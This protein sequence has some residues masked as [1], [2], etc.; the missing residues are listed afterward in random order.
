MLHSLTRARRA[1]RACAAVAP[2]VRSTRPALAATLALACASAS[3]APRPARAQQT[4]INI[5]SVDQTAKGRFFYLH[6]SQ[7]RDWGDSRFWQ[8][9]NFLTYGLAE[10]FELA[11]TTYNVGSPRLPT[12][13]VAPGWKTAQPILRGRLPAWELTLGA[14]QMYPVSLR[15]RGVGVWSY[16]QGALRLPGVRTR[17]MG[18]VSNGPG[19][20]FGKP[21]THV[22]TSYEQPLE[23]LGRRLGGR[24]GDAVGH[25]TLLGEWWS[26]THDFG[27]FVPG[28]NYHTKSIVVIVGYKLSNAPGTRSDGLILEVGRTF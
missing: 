20:L 10:R 12:S 17:L 14:G 5:P 24:V 19:L 7:L 13:A 27:D 15:G 6:E 2:R 28:I 8:T 9:T 23:A 25:M 18:G 1:R 22:I 11:V 21:T 3:L 16:A 26:G 4:I